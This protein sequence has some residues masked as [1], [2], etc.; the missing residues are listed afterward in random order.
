ML[1][2]Y[3][4]FGIVFFAVYIYMGIRFISQSGIDS[5]RIVWLYYSLLYFAVP[6]T[7]T[8]NRGFHIN[9]MILGFRVNYWISY[10]CFGYFTI[11]LFFLFFFDVLK[12]LCSCIGS[13]F[14]NSGLLDAVVR[15]LA[16]ADR[17]FR[18]TIMA[19]AFVCVLMGLF[20]A[21]R[22]IEINR[23]DIPIVKGA[24][25]LQGFSIVQISDLHISNTIGYYYVSDI[26]NMVNSLNPD[27]IVITGDLI[28]GNNVDYTESIKLLGELKSRFGVYFVTG[29]HEY[30]SETQK[31]CNDIKKLGITVLMN[32][33]RVIAVG[34]NKLLVAG[35]TDIS[36]GYYYKNQQC[37]PE[38]A[39]KV[40]QEC[41]LKILLAHQPRTIYEAES[42]KFDLQLS[43]HTHGG[44][45]YP[46]GLIVKLVQPFLKGLYTYK[47]KL[48]FVSTGA[49]YWGPPL[50]IGTRSEIV[51]LTLVS[52]IEVTQ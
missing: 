12:L 40:N 33:N 49:G 8:L 13:K 31:V 19:V 42:Y 2:F 39:L 7:E 34:K 32:E 50:R 15:G 46:P 51:K 28:D 35:V 4:V 14:P 38:K 9:P 44:Q 30:Y 18:I 5:K 52:K 11:A 23:V 21:T 16:F 6:I 41:N 37:D 17:H 25:D 27:L 48:L 20:N 22:S 26:V 45:F 3:V 47:G 43:G 36:A 29:D 10:I 24:P 1:L